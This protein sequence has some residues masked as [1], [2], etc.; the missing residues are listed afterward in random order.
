M[1]EMDQMISTLKNHLNENQDTSLLSLFEDNPKIFHS[2]ASESSVRSM[3]SAI[4]SKQVELKKGTEGI[5][6]LV[7]AGAG[8]ELVKK[9]LAVTDKLIGINKENFDAKVGAL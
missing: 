9:Y 2:L 5:M 4:I 1:I 8:K 6:E 7:N 3:L